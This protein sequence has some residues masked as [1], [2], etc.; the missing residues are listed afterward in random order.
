MAWTGIARAIAGILARR[1]REAAAKR[2][3]NVRDDLGQLWLR[4]DYGRLGLGFSQLGLS[5][6][7]TSGVALAPP[8]P[9][10]LGPNKPDPE[11]LHRSCRLPRV[12]R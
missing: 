10:S 6:G 8:A 5:G 7:V 1:F 2:L 11:A 3:G 4:R 9:S 12:P